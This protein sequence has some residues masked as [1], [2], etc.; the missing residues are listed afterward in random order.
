MTTSSGRV[1]IMWHVPPGGDTDKS[2]LIGVYSSRDA[3]LEA[4]A[5]LAGKPGFEDNPQVVDDADGPGFFMEAYT[6]DADHW[7]EGYR[8]AT[9][10][11]GWEP[12]PAWL[13]QPSD[14]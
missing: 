1:W 9:D 6:L 5:R 2:M 13:F 11:D 3:A 12:L 10:A 8:I 7:E 14:E 4:V